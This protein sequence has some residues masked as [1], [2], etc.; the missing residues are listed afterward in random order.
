MICPH[1]GFVIPEDETIIGKEVEDTLKFIAEESA[2]EAERRKKH[3][4]GRRKGWRKDKP[5]D[6]YYIKL[7]K[8]CIKETATKGEAVNLFY[9]KA[10]FNSINTAHTYFY[11][12]KKMIEGDGK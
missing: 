7:V 6:D 12:F 9:E 11:K 3:P 8:Q 2:K 10:N 4:P 5:S 1:C